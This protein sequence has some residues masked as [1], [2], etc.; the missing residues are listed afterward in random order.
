VYRLKID[1]SAHVYI[2]NINRIDD[3]KWTSSAPRSSLSSLTFSVSSPH[4]PSSRELTGEYGHGRGPYTPLS[5]ANGS[6]PSR[7]NPLLT[8]TSRALTSPH[9]RPSSRNP[10]AGLHCASLMSA[11]ACPAVAIRLASCRQRG[12]SQDCACL[13]SESAGRVGVGWY[14]QLPSVYQVQ[15]RRRPPI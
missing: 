15:A 3:R 14:G 10:G 5:H 11:C 1:E 4:Q 9:S 2:P 12:G 6:M 13:T 8:S 7:P